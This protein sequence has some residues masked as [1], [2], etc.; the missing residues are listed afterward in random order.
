M[1]DADRKIFKQT[2]DT[3]V[4]PDIPY[5]DAKIATALCIGVPIKYELQKGFGFGDCWL[6]EHVLPEVYK[7]HYDRKAVMTLRKALL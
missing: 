3:Y 7:M 5:P 2:V 1:L 4:D 6:I